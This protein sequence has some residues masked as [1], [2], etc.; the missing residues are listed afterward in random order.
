MSVYYV[1]VV[2][3]FNTS[4]DGVRHH[5]QVNQILGNLIRYHWPDVV[6]NPGTG[7][8]IPITQWDQYRFSHD[9]EYHNAQGTMWYDFWVSFHYNVNILN[10]LFVINKLILQLRF[11]LSEDGVHKDH[12][13]AVF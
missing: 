11:K 4:F 8:L 3:W 12:A 9:G 1:F 2:S 6:T 10:V 7:E 5:R 13:S